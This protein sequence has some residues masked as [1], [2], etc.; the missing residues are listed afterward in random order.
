M[1]FEFE[2]TIFLTLNQLESTI[3]WTLF[4]SLKMELPASKFREIVFQLLFSLDATGEL[5]GDLIPF[6]MRELAV[7]KKYVAAA[8]L[9]AQAVWKIHD[10]LDHTIAQLTKEYSLERIKNVEKNVL[11]LALYEVLF[12]KELSRKIIFSE[13]YRLTRKF[14][15]HEGASFV[16]AIL[17]T[18][19]AIT[20]LQEQ[21][22]GPALPPSKIKISE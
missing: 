20:A 16:N 15:T 22:Y 13:A 10:S 14:G 7:S 6:I 21:E 11:R 9:K 2:S 12:E 19:S 18:L 3:Y 17:D 5:E 4:F 8:Y 1:P